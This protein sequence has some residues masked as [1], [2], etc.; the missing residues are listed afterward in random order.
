MRLNASLNRLNSAERMIDRSLSLLQEKL[1]IHNL[2]ASETPS[3][4]EIL[5]TDC[6]LVKSEVPIP[7]ESHVDPLRLSAVH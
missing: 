1:H 7:A 2:A 3:P 5:F 6:V 4:E